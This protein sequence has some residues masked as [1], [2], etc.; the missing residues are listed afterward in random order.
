[1]NLDRGDLDAEWWEA[2]AEA[3]LVPVGM[4][5][6]RVGTGWAELEAEKREIAQR[7]EEQMEEEERMRELARVLEEEDRIE[8]ER[9]RAWERHM[10]QQEMA[11]EERL[12][13]WQRELAAEEVDAPDDVGGVQIEDQQEEVPSRQ[14]TESPELPSPAPA[15]AASRRDKGK[16]VEIVISSDT[17]PDSES[18]DDDDDDDDEPEFPATSQPTTSQTF[19]I[20][21]PSTIQSPGSSN[22]A[23]FNMR[24]PNFSNTGNVRADVSPPSHIARFPTNAPQTVAQTPRRSQ[25]LA[26]PAPATPEVRGE[27]IADFFLTLVDSGV[28]LPVAGTDSLPMVLARLG[29]ST[30][31]DVRACFKGV[32]GAG[33]PPRWMKVDQR[34]WNEVWDHLMWAVVRRSCAAVFPVPSVLVEGVWEFQFL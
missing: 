15:P 8:D 7:R 22:F 9:M 28:T 31:P 4:S 14:G 33:K 18:S 25:R 20:N 1:M 26:G 27:P 24:D 32:A 2:F 16:A 30:E 6:P 12:R 13:E 29:A 3:G 10:E 17:E 21:A 5:D 34:V 19:H 23:P 11:E